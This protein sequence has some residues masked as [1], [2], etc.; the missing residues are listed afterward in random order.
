MTTAVEDSARLYS[1]VRSKTT[2]FEKSVAANSVDT[3]QYNTDCYGAS[4]PGFSSGGFESSSNWIAKNPQ[5]C[6]GDDDALAALH[7]LLHLLTPS[8]GSVL[9]TKTSRFP[10]E[11][12]QDTPGPMS[13]EIDKGSMAGIAKIAASN[14]ITINPRKYHQSRTSRFSASRGQD[15][16][17]DVVYNLNT[18]RMMDMATTARTSPMEYSIMRS[19]APRFPQAKAPQRAAASGSYEPNVRLLERLNDHFRK[20][21]KLRKLQEEYNSR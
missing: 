1:Q 20:Q 12:F 8:H 5:T 10:K 14:D 17:L 18:G 3:L 2:R 6:S 7:L 11:E 19:T 9:R 4:K 21:G 16:P 13:Y 15:Q